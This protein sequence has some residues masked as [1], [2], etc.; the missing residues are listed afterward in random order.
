MQRNVNLI[1]LVKS[2]LTRIY[3]F[4]AKIG[5][6]T[7]ENEPFHFHNLSNLQGFDFHRAVVSAGP[8]GLR[9]AGEDTHSDELVPQRPPNGTAL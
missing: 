5:F 4:V 8:C 6:D 1:D 2:F 3:Y 7:A 9:R